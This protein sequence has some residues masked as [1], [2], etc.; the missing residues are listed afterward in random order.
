MLTFLPFEALWLLW[1]YLR[2][3]QNELGPVLLRGILATVIFLACVAP[4]VLR[5]QRVFHAFIPMRDNFGAELYQSA[6]P[7]H[8]GFPYG[9]VV[10]LSTTDPEWQRYKQMG[11]LAY[12]HLQGE[13]GK[14]MIAGERV[15]FLRWMLMRVQFYWVGVPHPFDQGVFV[16][17]MRELDFAFLS[18]SGLLGLVLSLRNRVPG[19]VLIT[20]AFAILPLLY[21]TVT[22]QARFR[23]P[24]EPLIAIF[25]VYLLQSADRTRV[26]SLG[27]RSA[28]EHEQ[29]P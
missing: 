7:S 9:T 27:K 1:P 22:V 11:E 5:N 10:P 3:R 24:L 23:A 16:E 15:Q 26:L 21:Y 19:I 6:L 18:V 4:W 2:F 29:H 13:R 8:Y 20:G 17:A 14:A 12:N 25:S 28:Y